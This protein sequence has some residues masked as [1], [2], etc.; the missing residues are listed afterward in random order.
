MHVH[1]D[2]KD[3]GSVVKTSSMKCSVHDPEVMNSNL[4]WVAFIHLGRV[5]LFMSDMN[6]R[7]EKVV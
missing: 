7:N 6:Q 4:S 3:N 5:V 1:P 2:L